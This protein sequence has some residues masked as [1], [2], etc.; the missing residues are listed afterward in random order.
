MKALFFILLL[1]TSGPAFAQNAARTPFGLAW[2]SSKEDVIKL[3]V[4]FGPE[5]M[6]QFGQEFSVWS[7]PKNL[8]DVR[9]VYLYFG[10]N[11]KL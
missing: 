7:L 6:G 1:L 2:G 4:S 11:N 9:D 8:D 10:F 5:K 3:G